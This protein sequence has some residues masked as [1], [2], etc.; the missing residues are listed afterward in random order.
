M[1][2]EVRSR[3]YREIFYDVE[4]GMD[5]KE[6]PGSPDLQNAAQNQD[7]QAVVQALLVFHEQD[8][9]IFKQIALFIYH[10]TKP[11]LAETVRWFLQGYMQ[12]RPD[13]D[14]SFQVAPLLNELIQQLSRIYEHEESTLK[15]LR[16]TIVELF[17]YHIVNRHCDANECFNNCCF[18]ERQI[19]Y[20]SRQVDV[21]V[22]SPTRKEIEGYTCKMR[23]EY[24]LPQDCIN[25]TNVSSQAKNIGYTPYTG[26]ICFENRRKIRQKLEDCTQDA[27]IYAYGL[28]NFDTLA[29]SPATR[30]RDNPR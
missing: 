8:R 7:V 30:H 13:S 22:L 27:S 20:S 25:L 18:V 11:L 10:N 9:D 1:R 15:F 12:P 14:G 29:M 6:A 23:P 28:D 24:L 16:G 3:K 2:N 21:A 5:L 19:G 26:V 4:V 17:A